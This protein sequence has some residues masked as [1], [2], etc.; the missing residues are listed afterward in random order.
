MENDLYYTKGNVLLQS[1]DED[2]EV[3]LGR[4]MLEKCS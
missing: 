4:E 3:Q 1:E 2:R